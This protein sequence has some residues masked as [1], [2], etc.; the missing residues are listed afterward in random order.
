MYG[1]RYSE[2]QY[3]SRAVVSVS[4]VYPDD[5]MVDEEWCLALADWHH[6]TGITWIQQWRRS[7]FKTPKAVSTECYHFC[8]VVTLVHL[9]PLK[10]RSHLYLVNLLLISILHYDNIYIFGGYFSR[11][12]C[13][14]LNMFHFLSFIL[15]KLSFDR[16][17]KVCV[18]PKKRNNF[19]IFEY[20]QRKKTLDFCKQQFQAKP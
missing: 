12:F 9:K 11:I 20:T 7:K 19:K 18:Q 16:M 5:G 13:L 6:G 14:L 3:E 17:N 8:V 15:Q 4:S 2:W 1:I 10:I